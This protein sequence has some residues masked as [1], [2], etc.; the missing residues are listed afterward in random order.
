MAVLFPCSPVARASAG[1]YRELDVLE[2]LQHGLPPGYDIFHSV[3]WHSL[4]QGQDC[5]GEIDLVVMNQAGELL[6]VEIKAGDVMFQDEGIFKRYSDKTKRVDQQIKVQ[7]SA[8]VGRLK[9]AGIKTSVKN[10]L[11]LPDCRV[12]SGEIIAIPRERIFDAADFDQLGNKVLQLLP[13]GEPSPVADQLRRFL[14]NLLNI[15]PDVSAMQSQI[16]STSRKLADG[17]ATWVP[18]ID[19]PSGV[20]RIQATAG[21]GKTQLALRLLE[22]AGAQK[23]RALYV[24]YNRPLSDH[25]A[26]L[27][28][29]QAQVS[30]FHELCVD[31]YRRK[32]GEP[33]FSVQGIFQTIV[34]HYLEAMTDCEAR[35]DLL[36]IDEAQDFAPEWVGC[37]I[38]QLKEHGALYLME[39][40]DQRLYER[41]GFELSD[42]VQ[43]RCHDNFRSPQILCQTIN[44]FGLSSHPI[45][46]RSPYQGNAPE[47]LICDG[48]P[49]AIQQQTT[50]AVQDLLEQG[51][52]VSDIAI[53]S[54]HGADHSNLLKQDKLGA[55][56]IRRFTGRYTPDSTPIWTDGELLVES[57]YRFKGQSA[58]AVILSEF[59]FTELTEHE[60]RKLFVGLTR[61]Q[62]TA[63]LVLTETAAKALEKMLG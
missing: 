30:T 56:T 4:H 53:L 5:H 33:D 7:Y 18:R 40:E 32:V 29:S 39:D 34:Q 48:S 54:G 22:N 44:A 61:A 37:L 43:L 21:S 41:D 51:F 46:A 19:A 31:H 42:A 23:Q 10:C 47:F 13:Q 52:S 11:V 57:V 16:V 27:A 59:D 8:M 35:L 26:R 38:G 2:R 58:P 45:E 25:I 3:D 20:I 63:K 1:Y 9:H 12:Q 60:R 28:P 6:L 36:I 24:C 14:G 15:A 17:L 49:Q 50:Q 62:V 55:H